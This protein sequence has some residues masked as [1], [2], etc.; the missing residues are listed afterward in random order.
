MPIYADLTPTAAVAAARRDAASGRDEAWD[1]LDR[2][3]RWHLL[4][5]VNDRRGETAELREALLEAADWSRQE[6]RTPWQHTW[7]YLLELLRDEERLPSS[8][9]ELRALVNPEGR[10]AQLLA[11]LAESEDPMRPGDLGDRLGLSKQRVSHLL[12]KLEAS[13]LIA[14]R[15]GKGRAVW[16][17]ATPRGLEQASRLPR[18]EGT[19]LAPASGSAP[20]C[21]LWRGVEEPVLGLRA[22]YH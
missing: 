5:Y 11:C 9:E 7:P 17:C 2:Y 13:G 4:T 20:E 22:G 14:R 12:R 19:E 6:D 8:T 18:A 1:A 16:L 15:K 10:A 21:A 3:L